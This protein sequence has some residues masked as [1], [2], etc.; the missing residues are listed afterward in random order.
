MVL[1]R[2]GVSVARRAFT[3]IELLVVIAIIAVLIGLLLPAVQKVREAAARAKCAN[4]L[5]QVALAVHNYHDA[6]GTCP[7]GNVFRQGPP[8]NLYDH[9]ECWA[10]S[11]LPYVEQTAVYNLWDSKLPNPTPDALSPPMGQVRKA[12]VSVYNC[13]SDISADLGFVP[14]TPDT[15]P[16]GQNG[17]GRPLFMP[18]TYRANAGTTFGGANGF[19]NPGQPSD[20]GG[21]RNWDDAMNTISGNANLSQAAWLMQTQPGWRGFMYGVDKRSSMQPAKITDAS[22]GTSNTLM[23]GEYATRTAPGRW[24]FWAYAYS[25]YS[26]SD[27]TIA[28]SRTLIPDYNLCVVTPP[29]RDNQCK[30]SWGSFHTGGQL[31]FAFG[32]GSVRTISPNID[33]NTVMPALGSI[34][35]GEVTPNLQ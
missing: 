12:L 14:F 26:L 8:N 6:V 25:S 35:G 17:Y 1:S 28:Q 23:I 13:P 18:S 30:R 21:D 34:A 11:I 22:D 7:A 24:T 5:K 32:D 27:V 3:L 31:N 10:I 20:T 33:V 4:N 15:G 29:L 2:P 9:Y 19:A 16:N